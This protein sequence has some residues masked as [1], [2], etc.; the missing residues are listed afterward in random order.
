MNLWQAF[1]PTTIV[2]DLKSLN[3]KQAGFLSAM[4]ITMVG[5]SFYWGDSVVGVVAGVT[6]VTCVFLVNLRKL[7]NFAW[8]AV[9]AVLYGYV[10]YS[11]N[12]YGDTMLNWMFY[13]PIQFIAA[14][15]WSQNMEGGEVISRKLSF[16]NLYKYAILAVIVCSS[17]SIVLEQ[18]GGK[19]SGVDATT[20]VLSIL[21]T[22]FMVK[23]YREQWLC[24]IAVNT[25]SIAMWYINSQETGAGYGVLVMWVMFLANS[26]YG[27][28][29]WFKNS[30][31]E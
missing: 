9:N 25:L 15:Y 21:A 11:A 5:L 20:T 12:Y 10:A 24:W 31:G 27:V 28:Y 4:L 26:V 3:V 8:G 30:K 14:H 16:N 19:L 29:T 1:N 17:Y 7:S 13:L 22:F 6:G 23:G 2:S 18:L